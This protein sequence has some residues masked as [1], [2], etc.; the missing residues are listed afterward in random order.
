[1][2]IPPRQ[3]NQVLADAMNCLARTWRALLLP[4]LAASIPMSIATVA[5]FRFTGGGD[6]LE[7]A[8]NNP[9]R[10]QGLASEVFA[11]LAT[12]FYV[13]LGVTTLLQLIAAVFIALAAHM[14]VA[15]D[16]A[17][18]PVDGGTIVR[19]ALRRYPPGLAAALLAVLSVALL[20]GLGITVWLVPVLSVGTPNTG[21]ELV[22]LLLLAVL[23]GPGIWVGVSFSMSTATLALE[24]KGPL[25][26]IRRSM[27]LVR[28]RWW[29]TAG[30]LLIVGLLG[31]IAVQLIQL[32]ALPLAS[33][34]GSSAA[35]VVA[36]A[37]GVVTQGLLV[38]GISVIYTHWYLDL[39]ARRENLST[40]DLG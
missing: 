23:I 3:F 1:M 27:R 11:E 6:F 24:N 21:T 39:R 14:A 34:G 28:G 36:S 40:S 15:G 4:A 32:V 37:L 12:P 13:A 9:E 29:P 26:A 17:G 33:V 20:L 7:T 5:I 38:A 30:F 22:A 19:Q 10:L 18:E 31:G 16:V 25:S 2:V 8:V 35:L